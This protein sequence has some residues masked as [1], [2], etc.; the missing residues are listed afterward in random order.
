MEVRTSHPPATHNFPVTSQL[1]ST[2]VMDLAA[3]PSL[4]PTT[5]RNPGP[6]SPSSSRLPVSSSE[7]GETE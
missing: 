5:S 6:P 2:S 7:A 1:S 3:T 4:S